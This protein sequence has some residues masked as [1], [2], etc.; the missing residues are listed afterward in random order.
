MRFAS[1][2]ESEVGDISCR[3]SSGNYSLLLPDHYI[4]NDMRIL[5]ESLIILIAPGVISLII[6]EAELELDILLLLYG[7]LS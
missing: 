5:V 6:L 4:G 1:T 2:Y 3:L 7:L